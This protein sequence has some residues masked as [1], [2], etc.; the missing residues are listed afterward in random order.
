VIYI[1]IHI[2][3]HISIYI[4]IYIYRYTD[5]RLSIRS[6]LFTHAHTSTRTRMHEE[7]AADMRTWSCPMRVRVCISVS[8]H[9]SRPKR[10]YHTPARAHA[11]VHAVMDSIYALIHIHMCS[12]IH[13]YMYKSCGRARPRRSRR[14]FTRTYAHAHTRRHAVY[15]CSLTYTYG[16]RHTQIY[17]NL[18]THS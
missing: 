14:A 18:V 8:V 12:H 1:Y 10:P 4:Y 2:Y 9:A 15:I 11:P 13:I 3:I 7:M 5:A 6:H 16:L 17:M